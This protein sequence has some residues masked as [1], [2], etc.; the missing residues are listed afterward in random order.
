MV[1]NV[2]A[3]EHVQVAA[4]FLFVSQYH[5]LILFI[6]KLLK[7]QIINRFWNHFLCVSIGEKTNACRLL[8][9]KTK[10]SKL[11]GRLRRRRVDVIKTRWEGVAWIHVVQERNKWLPFVCLIVS[12][13]AG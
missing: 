2:I 4:W 12:Y 11:L 10:V 13:L 7:A 3:A 9:G 6:N 1:T 5:L 8:V